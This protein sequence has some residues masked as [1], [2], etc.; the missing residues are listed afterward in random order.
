MQKRDV[1]AALTYFCFIFLKKSG[2]TNDNG[3]PILI[4]KNGLAGLRENETFPIP[5]RPTA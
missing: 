2:G 3:D 5:A 4:L 1:V